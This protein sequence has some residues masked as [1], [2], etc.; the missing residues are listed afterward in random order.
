MKVNQIAVTIKAAILDQDQNWQSIQIGAEAEIDPAIED[1]TEAQEQLF[2]GLRSNLIEYASV[3]VTQTK[4]KPQTPPRP[5]ADSKL[6][7]KQ[8]ENVQRPE[9]RTGYERQPQARTITQD[10]DEAVCPVHNTA[11]ASKFGGLYCPARDE[12]TGE[13]CNWKFK[14]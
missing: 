2:M 14:G 1:W 11:K 6:N 5:P 4:P 10:P 9:P 3:G 12:T 8:R 13:Y 7:G